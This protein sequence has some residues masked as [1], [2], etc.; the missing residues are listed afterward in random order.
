MDLANADKELK[1]A[2]EELEKAQEEL[3]KAQEK[4]EKATTEKLQEFWMTNVALWT[5]EIQK[6]GDRMWELTKPL[7]GNIFLCCQAL[8]QLHHSFSMIS[9]T[10]LSILLAT[11]PLT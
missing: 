4:L 3:K 5:N 6:W 8:H 1:K 2:Q 11:T 7:T 9:S 10:I